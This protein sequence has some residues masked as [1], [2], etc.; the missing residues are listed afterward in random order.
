[1]HG[2]A[3]NTNSQKTQHTQDSVLFDSRSIFTQHLQSIYLSLQHLCTYICRQQPN[4][5]PARLFQSD[6][7]DGVVGHEL[8]NQSAGW[9]S[10]TTRTVTT[11]TQVAD[12]LGHLDKKK[13]RGID[14][15][16]A[17]RVSA[18]DRETQ[19]RM[20]EE[21]ARQE[22]LQ[23][24]QVTTRGFSFF[25]SLLIT[26]PHRVRSFFRVGTSRSIRGS[27][28]WTQ[29]VPLFHVTETGELLNV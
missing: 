26:V 10:L 5:T 4:H 21:H 8:K 9:L 20:A 27:L 29:G 13:G 17:V 11:T 18:D 12:S 3:G 15:V 19:R 1:M 14:A 23:R 6:S 28:T 16:T 25:L 22:R 7:N 2:N 24:L